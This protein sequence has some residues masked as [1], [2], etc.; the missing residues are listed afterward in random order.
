MID[1]IVDHFMIYYSIDEDDIYITS[2]IGLGCKNRKFT[3]KGWELLI[4]CKYNN[5][6][7]ATLKY[8]KDSNPIEAA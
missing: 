8:I 5:Q 3:M 2:Y 4:N 1:A 7:W 6:S